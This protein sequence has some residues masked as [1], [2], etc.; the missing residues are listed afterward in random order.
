MVVIIPHL[1]KVVCEFVM[2]MMMILMTR[3][4]EFFAGGWITAMP[5]MEILGLQLTGVCQDRVDT[6]RRSTMF[7]H[8]HAEFCWVGIDKDFLC[9]MCRSDFSADFIVPMTTACEVAHCLLFF[10]GV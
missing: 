8:F 6:L 10:I 1:K 2:M 5:S 9:R 3:G 7:A 4:M